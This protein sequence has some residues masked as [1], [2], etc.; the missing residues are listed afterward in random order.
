LEWINLDKY[1]KF[2][3]S[4]RIF[5]RS[6][7]NNTAALAFGGYPSPIYPTT[8][9]ATESWNGSSWTSVNSIEHSKR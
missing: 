9:A 6:R 3:Y 8:T 2:K 4:K 7:C 1:T 5:G